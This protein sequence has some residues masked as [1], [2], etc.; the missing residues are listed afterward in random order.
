MPD[1]LLTNIGIR[2]KCRRAADQAR[3]GQRQH[4]FHGADECSE[5]AWGFDTSAPTGIS[6][7][8]APV[9]QLE[10]F[11][12]QSEIVRRAQAQVTAVASELWDEWIVHWGGGAPM[13]G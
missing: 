11:E 5:A 7:S 8:L 4:G 9:L 1:W 6:G 12:V 13:D 3:G 10:A 2:S